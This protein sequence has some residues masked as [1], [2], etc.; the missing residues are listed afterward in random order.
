[1]IKWKIAGVSFFKKQNLRK[2]SSV[3]SAKFDRIEFSKNQEIIEETK[4][5]DEESDQSSGISADEISS[6]DYDEP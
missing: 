4:K 3:D 2:T 1:M 6:T 5:Q